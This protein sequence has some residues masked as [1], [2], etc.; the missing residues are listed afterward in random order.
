MS[1][2]KKPDSGRENSGIYGQDSKSSS[3]MASPVA[4]GRGLP[5]ENSV[6]FD[7]ASN[8]AVEVKNSEPDL[9]QRITDLE[10]SLALNKEVVKTLL[11]AQGSNDPKDKLI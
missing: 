9:K 1:P 2:F 7:L 3:R 5:S 8:N 11:E 10:T 4:I 6:P